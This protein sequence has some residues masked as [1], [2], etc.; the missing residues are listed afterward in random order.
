MPVT[1]T[2]R[3]GRRPAADLDTLTAIGRAATTG[4]GK[5]VTRDTVQTAIRD[6]GLTIGAARL[7]EVVRR[8][9]NTTAD[10]AL[11]GSAAPAAPET[12]RPAS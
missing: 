4:Q 7:A 12:A 2:P 3:R 8:L 10:N 9:K 5:P 6:Q 11:G 1:P